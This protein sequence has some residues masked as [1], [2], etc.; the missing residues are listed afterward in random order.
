MVTKKSLIA[1]PGFE[2]RTGRL[3]ELFKSTNFNQLFKFT[4][5]CLSLI[6][7]RVFFVKKEEIEY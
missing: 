3:R 6:L 7:N 5:F 1:V 4:D 2:K